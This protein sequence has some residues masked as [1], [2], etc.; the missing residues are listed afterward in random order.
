MALLAKTGKPGLGG[1]NGISRPKFS[2]QDALGSIFR[3][4]AATSVSPQKENGPRRQ[5]SG[6]SIVLEVILN[7][8]YFSVKRNPC[9]SLTRTFPAKPEPPGAACA[10]FY[11]RGRN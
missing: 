6:Q 5:T 9:R 1:Q 2:R 4:G 8:I 11:G 3:R 10:A 7:Q